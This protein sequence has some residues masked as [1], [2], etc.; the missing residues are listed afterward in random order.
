MYRHLYQHFLNACPG[1]LHFAAH[2][3]HWWPDVTREAQLACWDDAARWR[4]QKWE[5]LFGERIP[6]LQQ[7]LAQRLGSD[8]PG[9]LVFAPNTHEFVLRLLSC[10]PDERPLRVL[11]TTSEFHSLNRQLRRLEEGRHCQVRRL[12]A[13]PV[14]RLAEGLI[15]SLTGWQPDLLFVSQVFFDSGLVLAELNNV[16]EAAPDSTLVV[17]DGYHG[18]C[19]LPVDLSS[20]FGRCFYLAGGYKYAQAGEG[21]CFMHVPP[22]CRLRPRNTGWF[23]DFDG[24]EDSGDQP[25]GY[26]DGGQRF[27]GAT[28]DACGLY[29][30]QAVLELFDRQ[31]LSTAVIHHYV[32]SLQQH[33]LQQLADLDHSLLN[34]S[35]L[36]LE[37]GRLHGHFYSFD[38]PPEQARQLQQQLCDR[39]VIVDRR[40]CRLRIGFGLYQTSDDVDALFRILKTI[41]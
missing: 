7:L 4:D 41:D 3:H 38:L 27:A 28:F 23:A 32:H 25:L 16:A 24:L 30:L 19:A 31:Q 9:Q 15:D 35:S 39:G 10:L 18:F 36:V 22:D 1:Q 29:R 40:G 20:V 14:T 33:F 2:S 11:T 5:R 37:P 17:I 12:P 8:T 6:R 21:C 26:A 34:L 13:E